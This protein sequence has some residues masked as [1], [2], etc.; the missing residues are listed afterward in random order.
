[1]P[2]VYYEHLNDNGV[3]HANLDAI[4][5]LDYAWAANDAHSAMLRGDTEIVESCQYIV[6]L[7]T[8]EDAFFDRSLMAGAYI[9]FGTL[10]ALSKMITAPK[11]IYKVPTANA[12]RCG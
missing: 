10:G 8:N 6:G 9:G 7:K 2:R 3:M 12:H 1:M 5:G 11:E 4:A